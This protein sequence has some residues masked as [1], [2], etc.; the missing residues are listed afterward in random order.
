[1]KNTQ[2][3]KTF[4]RIDPSGTD[5]NGSNVRRLKKPVT[6][7]WREVTDETS[8]CAPFYEAQGTFNASSTATFTIT[9]DTGETL[10]V[11][12]NII[13][14]TIADAIN[15]FNSIASYI[16]RAFEVSATVI[17][18]NVYYDVAHAFAPTGSTFTLTVA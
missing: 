10:V 2:G 12:T 3:L 9:A 17:G 15:A 8:C 4:I 14:V 6:G 5:I 11:S 16:G 7:R 13:T 18:I 1:M